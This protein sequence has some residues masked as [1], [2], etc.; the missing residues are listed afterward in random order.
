[1]SHGMMLI[2]CLMISLILSSEMQVVEALCEKR[3]KTWS[4]W[5]GNSSHCDKQCREWEH[6]VNGTCHADFPGRA[7]FCYFN[8]C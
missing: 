5:C 1:S 6:A 3:S 7:C 2:L 4:G 8:S